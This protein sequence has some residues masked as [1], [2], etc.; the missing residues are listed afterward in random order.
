MPSDTPYTAAIKTIE[1]LEREKSQ[2][3]SLKIYRDGSQIDP[4]SATYTL[5]KPEGESVVSDVVATIDVDGTVSYT[6]SAGQLSSSLLLEEGYIQEWNVTISGIEYLFRRMAAVVRRRLYPT[7]SQNDL[8]HIYANLS[9]VRPSSITS[10]QPYIDDAWYQ[11]QRRI[12]TQN[13]GYPYLIMTAE[14]FFDCHRHL[15]LYL[16]FRDFHSALGQSNGRY[17]D[18]AQEHY[19]LYQDG[20]GQINFIYDQDNDGKAD[21]PDKRTRGQP[22]IYLNR[23]GTWRNRRR[24]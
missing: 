19:R 18:L 9:D 14:S 7:V 24:Y 20:W 3:T 17:L 5:I 11:I 22:T 12:R 6:H 10:Y 13:I 23:P 8:T 2:I 1:L 16:I 15:S 4:T 21:D